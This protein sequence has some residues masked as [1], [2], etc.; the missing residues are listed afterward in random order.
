VLGRGIE[1][2]HGVPCPYEG[3][4]VMSATAPARGVADRV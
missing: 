3:G 2:G 4:E 1:D